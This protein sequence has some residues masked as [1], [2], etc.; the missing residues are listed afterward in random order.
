LAALV[1]LALPEQYQVSG[2]GLLFVLVVLACLFGPASGG[3]AFLV[4]QAVLGIAALATARRMGFTWHRIGGCILWIIY[5]GG[6]VVFLAGPL[7][8]GAVFAFGWGGETWPLVVVLVLFVLA[9]GAGCV[10]GLWMLESRATEPSSPD[11]WATAAGGF[12][13]GCAVIY[14]LVVR[15]D[16]TTTAGDNAPKYAGMVFFVLACFSVAACTL[17]GYSLRAGSLLARPM[18]PES[19]A[20]T[21]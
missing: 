21:R 15:A 10:A 12:A 18:P 2:L 6:A 11:R 4:A 20:I 8:L 17:A 14:F 13:A 16:S 5:G 3:I 9:I 7:A 1:W 19:H